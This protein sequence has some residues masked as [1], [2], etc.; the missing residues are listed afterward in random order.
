[1]ND[2][3][4]NVLIVP[5][6][7][8]PRKESAKDDRLLSLGQ[9]FLESVHNDDVQKFCG[10]WFSAD[11]RLQQLKAAGGI[12]WTPDVIAHYR[13][14]YELDIELA[15][16]YHAIYRASLKDH[17]ERLQDITLDHVGKT[18]DG[19]TVSVY[20]RLPNGSLIEF[21][22]DGVHEADGGWKFYGHPS[23]LLK[24]TQTEDGSSEMIITHPTTPQ[25]ENDLDRVLGEIDAAFSE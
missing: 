21:Q 18:A 15:A 8:Y 12:D 19:G 10:C 4:D 3:N 20:V 23:P 2:S 13:K 24:M 11:E 6:P 14:I 5:D 17:C 16:I 1:M 25:M 9:Q 22:I 7:I